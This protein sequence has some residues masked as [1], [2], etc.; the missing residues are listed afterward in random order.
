MENVNRR[1]FFGLSL[2]GFLAALCPWRREPTS[3]DVHRKFTEVLRE[4]LHHGR[5]KVGN[6]AEK[7]IVD[8]V[9]SEVDHLPAGWGRA[10]GHS[11]FTDRWGTK[12]TANYFTTDR[13]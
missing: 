6:H 2:G 1:S 9:V 11:Y 4:N 12:R 7:L 10:P 8:D 5:Y 13:K 3:M